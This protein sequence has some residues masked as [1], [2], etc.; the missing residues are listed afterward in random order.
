[1]KPSAKISIGEFES[2]L[3]I[4]V[5]GRGTFQTSAPIK[6]LVEKEMTSGRS[7]FVIDLE[8]C[9]GMDSTFMGM[10]AGIGMRLRKRG[11]GQLSI[12]GTCE[13]SRDS[14]DELGLA[15]LMEIEP[16]EGPWTNQIEEI[17]RCL[18]VLGDP[19]SDGME[20]HILECHENLC[21]ADDS[22]AERFKTVLE[23]LGSDKVNPGNDKPD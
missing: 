7:Q 19:S 22:N 18:G 17:R 23:V 21:D 10:M 1:V 8:E 6:E 4:R 20:E 3:W 2:I 9:S 12:V 15:Y 5:E 14:L 11:G 16:E 13:K